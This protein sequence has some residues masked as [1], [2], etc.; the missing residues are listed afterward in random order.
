MSG[1]II[2]VV[3]NQIERPCGKGTRKSPLSYRWTQGYNRVVNGK[4][5]FPAVTRREAIAEARRD[6]ATAKFISG[7]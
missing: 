3:G 5:T 4:V 6:G 1:K 2:F 7:L